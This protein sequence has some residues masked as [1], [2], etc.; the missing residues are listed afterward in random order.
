MNTM[1]RWSTE[2]AHRMSSNCGK[3]RCDWIPGRPMPK[4]DGNLEFWK[5]FKNISYVIT[6]CTITFPSNSFTFII[7]VIYYRNQCHAPTIKYRFQN[8]YKITMS[9]F[10]FTLHLPTHDTL[11]LFSQSNHK[12]ALCPA[13]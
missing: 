11:F 3:G 13:S 12:T 6:S 9:G 7:I 4:V 1:V 8:N 5:Y 10:F 2:V